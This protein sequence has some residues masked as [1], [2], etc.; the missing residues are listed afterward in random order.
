MSQRG[1]VPPPMFDGEDFP[2]WKARMESYLEDWDPGC[3]KATV[4]GFP[5]LEAGKALTDAQI[6]HNKWNVKARNIIYR[7]IGKDVFNRVRNNKDAHDLWTSICAL[8]EGTKSEREERYHLVMHKLNSFAMLPN[9]CANDMYSRLNL[10]VEELNGLGLN[11]MQPADVAR[12]ILCLLPIEKY[13]HIVTVLHQ[14][15]LSTAT[16]TQILGKI[17]AHDT[18]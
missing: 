13:G 4:E 14:G 10:L 17:N 6:E 11:Q 16:P 3:L 12:K 2:Y 1:E 18:S 7:G 5:K 9:E 8:H 15:D